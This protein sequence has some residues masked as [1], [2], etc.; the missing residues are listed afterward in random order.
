[1]INIYTSLSLSHVQTILALLLSVLGMGWFFFLSAVV[2]VKALRSLRRSNNSEIPILETI[3]PITLIDVIKILRI[4]RIK[5]V[6][7]VSAMVIFGLI[8]TS[9][10]G[11]IVI[12][13]VHYVETCKSTTVI[14]QA[15]ITNVDHASALS[16]RQL[17]PR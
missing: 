3:I 17:L 1:M 14:S 15:K 10:E 12:N 5:S 4:K 16:T 13:S 9:F 7:F 2:K 11:I 6:V 8:L